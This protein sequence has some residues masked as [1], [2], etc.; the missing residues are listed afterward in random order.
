[1]KKFLRHIMGRLRTYFTHPTYQKLDKLSMLLGKQ[2]SL[3]N[4]SRHLGGGQTQIDIESNEFSVYSQNGEDGIIDFLLHYVDLSVYPR[5]FVEF[6]VENYTESNTRFLLKSR[7]FQGLVID[8]S[9]EHIDYIKRDEIYWRY[10]LHAQCAFITKD[11]INAIIKEWLDS[12]DLDNVAL[13]SIDIDGNDYYVW[14]HLTCISPA[15]VVIE[16]N[17]LFGST[18]SVSIPYKE[19]FMRFEAHHSGLYFGA[20]I[21]ALID[22]GKRKGYV[23]VGADSSGTNLFFLKQECA[24]NIQSLKIYPLEEYCR[25]HH[26][27][28]SR[29]IN[30]KLDFTSHT[31]RYDLIATLPLNHLEP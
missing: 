4:S 17:A 10:D 24:K 20:S 15:I 26:A 22:L 23:F 7:N 1:M 2:L 19:D 28:Q 30:G 9:Q 31:K 3:H 27:R 21:K 5:A 16:Y 8:G 25:R 14:E 6:G 13:L 18:Q 12:R 29:D 11:N